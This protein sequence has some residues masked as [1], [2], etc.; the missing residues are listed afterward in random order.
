MQGNGS[1]YSKSG[2]A[3]RLRNYRNMPS[4]KS[5]QPSAIVRRP[6]TSIQSYAGTS[7]GQVC[8][9]PDQDQLRNLNEA[10]GLLQ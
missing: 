3:G 1:Q 2:Q 7:Y 8:L 6:Q 4:A 9:S 5:H 10:I